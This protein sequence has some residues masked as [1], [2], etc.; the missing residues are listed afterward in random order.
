MGDYLMYIFGYSPS[1]LQLVTSLEIQV[2]EFYEINYMKEKDK[3]MFISIE[4]LGIEHV[5]FY[6]LRIWITKI[7]WWSFL[8]IDLNLIF[9]KPLKNEF[10]CIQLL[11]ILYKQ[12]SPND[13][14]RVSDVD[15]IFETWHPRTTSPHGSESHQRPNVLDL[16]VLT[17]AI[18]QRQK[19]VGFLLGTWTYLDS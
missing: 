10:L 5:D 12:T 3:G 1:F 9:I 6:F 7:Y 4:Y 11:Y 17:V 8:D 13:Q 16:S 14:E 18:Y 19:E 2:I 15:T